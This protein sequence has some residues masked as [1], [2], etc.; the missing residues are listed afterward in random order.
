MI[1]R[2][3]TVVYS[4]VLAT[5]FLQCGSVPSTYYYRVNTD[6][7]PATPANSP[8]P[9]VLAVGAFEADV[10]Y[11]SDRIVFRNSPFEVQYYH[12]RR[13]VAPPK[14]LVSDAVL[15]RFKS[16]GAFR[17][18]LQQPTTSATDY[19]LTGKILSFEEWDEADSWFGS[20]KIAFELY[21]AKTNDL[22]WQKTYSERK[23]AGDKQPVAVV[24]SISESLD[25]VIQNVLT[26]VAR[27]LRP[28]Q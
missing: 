28:A 1:K 6:D 5:L 15:N 12:Y 27:Q 22:V 11:E 21:D 9:V 4:V 8:I 25:V 26:D 24:Q 17:E 23:R 18:V 19:L 16:A 13:W 3:L 14:K 7:A 10:V 20:V 2:I